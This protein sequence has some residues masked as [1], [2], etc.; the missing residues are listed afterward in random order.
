MRTWLNE[1]RSYVEPVQ[2]GEWMRARGAGRVVKSKAEGYKEGD[3]VLGDFGWQEYHVGAPN[4]YTV[5]QWV[6]AARVKAHRRLPPGGEVKDFVGLF[7]GAGLTSYFVR[8]PVTVK[9][10]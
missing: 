4:G 7:G 1:G 8:H 3:L 10:Y 9:R 6:R 2:I 5:V